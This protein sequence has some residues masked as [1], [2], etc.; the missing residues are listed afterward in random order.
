M[1]PLLFLLSPKVLKTKNEWC[2]YYF[3]HWPDFILKLKRWVDL[4]SRLVW[5]ILFSY[6]RS[7]YTLGDG[8]RNISTLI[9]KPYLPAVNLQSKQNSETVWPPEHSSSTG[10]SGCG[11]PWS[12]CNSDRVLGYVGITKA[13]QR[14]PLKGLWIISRLLYSL[15]QEETP[16]KILL[17]LF[18]MHKMPDTFIS[19]VPV[20][21][22]DSERCSYLPAVTQH[23]GVF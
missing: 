3:S 17:G 19:S 7:V 21:V 18:F 9:C 2:P 11:P 14:C 1:V 10:Y 16:N 6:S 15:A 23:W 13:Q 5:H 4:S 22:Q 8:V 20:V 12:P